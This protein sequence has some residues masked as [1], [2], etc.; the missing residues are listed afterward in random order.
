MSYPI[1]PKFAVTIPEGSNSYRIEKGC[2]PFT[3]Q[4]N[5]HPL[6]VDEARWQLE[7]D[8]AQDAVT[9][10]TA[11]IREMTGDPTIRPHAPGDAA[12]LL[13]ETM[14]LKPP[15]PGKP[16]KDGKPGRPSCDEEVLRHLQ[17][18]GVEVAGLLA[19]ARHLQSMLS[20]I[21]SW[22]E[23]AKYGKV[24]ATWNQ[25]GTPHGRYSCDSPN[26][27]N[28]IH[29][30]RHTVVADPGHSFLSLDLGQAE[31]VTWAS[32]S[33]DTFLSSSFESGVDF[34][35]VTWTEI[36]ALV[37]DVRVFGESERASGK[38]INFAVLYLM[39]A[40]SLAQRLGCDYP[41]AQAILNAHKARAPRASAYIDEVLEQARLNGCVVTTA[42]G[43]ERHL[44]DLR[45]SNRAAKHQA[46]KTAW[47]HHNAGTAAEILK[48]KQVNTG[49]AL[50]K[51]FGER[52]RLSL[53][54]HDELIYQIPDE[55]LGEAREAAL[56]AFNKPINGFL[57]FKV[58]CRTGK[59]WGDI[60]K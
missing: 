21:T 30:I 37:P 51:E 28:R 46:N 49:R 23:F 35:Q 42:F 40:N 13:F 10:I 50:H 26:L 17:R 16:G 39:Q 25:T 27:Q 24:Q 7:L 29:P 19:D 32:L 9:A 12:K 1:D 36:S 57:P 5:Q 33:N 58:D 2:E 3:A 48:L 38:T 47:N 14:G 18:Q 52:V 6:R 31:Y 34:H 60:T 11:T 54:M 22:G 43:R 20:Q 55:I 53:Q 44:P 8:K 45:S 15:R 59:T 56:A 4:M 41:T